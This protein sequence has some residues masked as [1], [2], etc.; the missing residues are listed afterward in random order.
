MTYTLKTLIND[1]WTQNDLTSTWF[2]NQLPQ[3]TTPYSD[4]QHVLSPDVAERPFHALLG[5][6]GQ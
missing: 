6:P 1:T 3:L 2:T 4:G 5:H